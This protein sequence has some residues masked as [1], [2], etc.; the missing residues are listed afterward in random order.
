[1]QDIIDNSTN[2][3]L[4]LAYE[5]KEKNILFYSQKNPLEVSAMRGVAAEQAK[6]FASMC[7]TKETSLSLIKEIKRTI[8]VEQDF[9]KGFALIQEMQFRL[10]MI[11]EED[12]ILELVKLYYFLPNEDPNIP[13][14]SL[15]KLK[16]KIFKENP[17]VKAFF[18]QIGIILLDKFSMKSENDAILYLE[19]TRAIAERILNYLPSED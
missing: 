9:V 5:N 14:E 13:S 12:S 4:V 19:R 6:R 18:L 15:N 2:P 16:S 8:N 11:C 10:E 3:N 7:L 1:M 17:E